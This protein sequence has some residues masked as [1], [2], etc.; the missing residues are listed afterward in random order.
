MIATNDLTTKVADQSRLENGVQPTSTALCASRALVIIP[1]SVNYFYNVEGRRLAEALLNLGCQ[2]DVCTLDSFPDQ[3]YDWCFLLNIYE[4]DFAFSN[5]SAF[6]SR[7]NKLKH[8]CAQVVPTLLEAV[9]SKWFQD[10]YELL[11]ETDLANILDMGFEDQRSSL[12]ESAKRAYGFLFN[13]LTESE[14]RMALSDFKAESRPI[15]WTFVGQATAERLTLVE[16]LVLDYD[17]AGFV[18]LIRHV[19]YTED[20]P[21]LRE[22][23]LE[24]VL[25]RTRYKVWCSHHPYNY[26]ESIR[27][28]LA[29]LT[30]CVPIKIN[31]RSQKID[32]STPFSALIMEEN[33]CI[34]RI[35]S[36]DFQTARRQFVDE[37]CALP[38]LEASVLGLLS[39]W[40]K[41]S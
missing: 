28:R 21:H 9:Q 25:Q 19:P 24:Q 7:I 11:A 40:G 16:R 41:Q 33:D 23:Q 4:I 6:L 37:F 3:P 10:S 14:R 38:S 18:Y 12:P 1:G 30:G 17:P 32:N 15:P 35:R 31:L 39:Q 2:V 20:G 34:E 27:F 29:L 8:N 36:L 22:S 13:G 26:L 5:R